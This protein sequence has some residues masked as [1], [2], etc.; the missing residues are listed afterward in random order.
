VA[1]GRHGEM[2]RRYA[3]PAIVVKT[4]Q[5]F[6]LSVASDCPGAISMTVARD[7]IERTRRRASTLPSLRFPP[8]AR[9]LRRR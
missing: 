3:R 5:T 9:R 7:A 2:I 8:F 4:N 6:R 1:T